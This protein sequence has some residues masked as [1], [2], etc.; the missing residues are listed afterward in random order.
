MRVGQRR[1]R[2]LVVPGAIAC[3]IRYAMRRPDSPTG[4]GSKVVSLAMIE[5][6]SQVRLSVSAFIRCAF[7]LH[8]GLPFV[9][10]RGHRPGLPNTSVELDMKLLKFGSLFSQHLEML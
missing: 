2:P 8:F 7:L 10:V 4:Q 9:I 1:R 6:P 5:C 3:P